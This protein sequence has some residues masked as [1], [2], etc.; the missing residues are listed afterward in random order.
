VPGD[1]KEHLVS[2]IPAE[3]GT[4][5]TCIGEIAEQKTGVLIRNRNGETLSLPPGGYEHFK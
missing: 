4:A 2:T 1:N 3:T 5:L